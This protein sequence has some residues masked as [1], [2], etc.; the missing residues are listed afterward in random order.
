[1]RAMRSSRLEVGSIAGAVA[2]SATGAIGRSPAASGATPPRRTAGT[3]GAARS[4]RRAIHDATPAGA[5]ASGTRPLAHSSSRARA[6]LH[7]TTLLGHEQR[8]ATPT[9]STTASYGSALDPEQRP[10]TAHA[11]HPVPLQRVGTASGCAP[12]TDAGQRREREHLLHGPPPL[13]CLHRHPTNGT[14]GVRD[15]CGARAPPRDPASTTDLDAHN[16]AR[17]GSGVHS[18]LGRR[19]DGVEGVAGSGGRGGQHALRGGPATSRRRKYS[20]TIVARDRR[21]RWPASR[22][23]PSSGSSG[24]RTSA[25]TARPGRSTRATSRNTST[26]RTR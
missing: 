5:D 16:R 4:S 13:D 12:A 14:E 22:G 17:T 15:G 26:G 9:W 10:H 18:R 19:P 24:W 20:A 7:G 3:S 2:G 25:R 1:M 6:C 23:W 8:K 11:S 21:R